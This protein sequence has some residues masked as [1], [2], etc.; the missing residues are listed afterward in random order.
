M[1]R[2]ITFDDYVRGRLDDWGR[3]FALHR[4]CEI[5]GHKS[6]DM[7]AIIIEHGGE[8][9]PRATGFKPFTVPMQE[10]QIEDI[11]SGIARVNMRQ[12]H[13]L[14]AYYCGSGRQRVERLETARQL[15]REDL[16][17]RRYFEIHDA[18]FDVVR[19]TL[20]TMRQAA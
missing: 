4:D 2:I 14:R 16:P 13:V 8:L 15:L 18:A 12:A 3:V 17:L 5:L 6:K 10:M 1:S 7:L 11:V 19:D 20:K 9:P